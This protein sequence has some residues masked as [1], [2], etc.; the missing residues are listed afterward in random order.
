LISQANKILNITHVPSFE[1]I[2]SHLL[3]VFKALLLYK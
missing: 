1:S 2:F 3:Q